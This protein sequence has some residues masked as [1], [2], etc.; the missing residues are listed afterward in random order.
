RDRLRSNPTMPIYEAVRLALSTIRV[1]KLKSFFTLLGVCIGVMFL[2]T[3]VSIVEGMGAYMENDLV[4]KI[5]SINTVELRHRPNINIGDVDA[6]V[7]EEYRRRRRLYIDDVP[8]VVAVLPEGTKWAVTAE[9]NV[10]VTTAYSRPRSAQAYGIDGQFMEIK[11]WAISEGRPFTKQ[12]L[13][14]GENVVVI[15]PDVAERAFPGLDPVGREA[16]IGGQVYRVIGVVESQ[17]SALGIS[18]DNFVVAPYRSPIRRLLNRTPNIIDAVLI[19]G[20]NQDVLTEASELVRGVMRTRHKLRPGAKDDFALETSESAL[21]F[22]NKL[23]GY[24]VLAGI[25]LPAIGLVVGSIVIMNIMLVAV[26]ERTRE[27]GIRKALGAKRRDIMA[28][29]LVES[30]T[31]STVGALLG[32]ALGLG[33]S[34][35]IAAVSPLPAT[36]APWSIIVGVIVGA[37]VGI[38]SGVYPASRASLLDPITAL[39]QE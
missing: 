34:Q 23:K 14:Y 15:G 22:W 39:R 37:G 28:Q 21:E 16:K 32:I 6:S 36:V 35:L 1:Q 7:W 8:P 11:N 9:N 33:F 38:V 13:D 29:F 30:A 25:A 19:Q 24:L 31:L 27:I 17:G 4:G 18:F 12:E 3:V 26:A 5:I 10:T 2:I 20:Q